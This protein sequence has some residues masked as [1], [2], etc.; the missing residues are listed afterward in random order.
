VDG[1]VVAVP[2]R[3]FVIGAGMT[4]FEKPRSREWGNPDIG[5]EAGE[6]VES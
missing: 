3:T 5:R 4:K 6:M 2:K 1:T